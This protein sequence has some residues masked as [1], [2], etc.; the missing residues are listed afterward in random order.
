VQKGPP[1][2][3]GCALRNGL[4]NFLL[5]LFLIFKKLSTVNKAIQEQRTTR[6]QGFSSW[7]NVNRS[8]PRQIL[9]I[10]RKNLADL[11][12]ANIVFPICFH[13]KIAMTI[14]HQ[15][16]FQLSKTSE[17]FLSTFSIS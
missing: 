8:Q 5:N 2:T 6:K 4:S 10:P 15:R 14:A 11:S 1:C 7:A 9:K 3:I 12:P 16:S 13:L 17:G